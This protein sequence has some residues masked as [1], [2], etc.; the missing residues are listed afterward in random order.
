MPLEAGNSEATIRRN[1]KTEIAAGKSQKQAEAIALNKARSD[2][3]AEQPTQRVPGKPLNYAAARKD[4]AEATGTAKLDAA[5]NCATA[6]MDRMD[7]R[8]DA[9]VDPDTDGAT[10]L[11]AGLNAW[12]NRE[13]N[14]AVAAKFVSA[15]GSKTKIT[16]AEARAGAK[17]AGVSNVRALL[18][19]GT[20]RP[21][22]D[23]R[24]DAAG[25]KYKVA[26]V[27]KYNERVT[28]EVMAVDREDA[29][30]KARAAAGLTSAATITSMVLVD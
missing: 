14:T 28:K 2:S 4:A 11:L 10:T 3:F 6:I 25:T 16:A 27:G 7:A 19:A 17:A 5:L 8:K 21:R 15:V 29:K 1:I 30:K 12:I 26:M 24:K 22:A 9:Q 18:A 20:W 13:Y 23:A